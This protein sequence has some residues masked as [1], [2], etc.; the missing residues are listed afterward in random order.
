MSIIAKT[1]IEHDWLALV[2]TLKQLDGIDIRVVSH[3]NTAPGATGFPFLVEYEDRMELEGA[4]DEDPT[5]SSYEL[6]D[7]TEETGIYYIEHT[8]ETQYISTVVTEVNGFMIQTRTDGRGWVV[9]ALL[10][11]REALNTIWEYA[12]EH[13]I[14]FDINEIYSSNDTGDEMYYGLTEEQRTALELAY[15]D[16]YFGEPRE[17]SLNEV[18]EELDLSST[19]TSGRLRRGMGNLISATIIDQKSEN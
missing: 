5:V 3:G 2:P 1:Y 6:V 14:K 16:G 15:E 8:Q 18:A 11:D 9:R 13:D 12:K 19:A 10:P 17:V 4:L 7:W